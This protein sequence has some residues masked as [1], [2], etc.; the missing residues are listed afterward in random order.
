MVGERSQLASVELASSKSSTKPPTTTAPT[1]HAYEVDGRKRL[2]PAL[3]AMPRAAR[4][5]WA[6]G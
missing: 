6:P 5:G 3:G 4:A 1:W 2:L